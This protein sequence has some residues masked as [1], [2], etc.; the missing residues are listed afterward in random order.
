MKT[1]GLGSKGGK[2]APFESVTAPLGSLNF[3]PFAF[4]VALSST[5]FLL[6]AADPDLSRLP[7]PATV[8][9][10]FERDIRPIF[11]GHCYK[12][13]GPERPKG[14]FQLTSRESALKGGA[15]N[16]DDIIP[17]D[18][19]H[20]K[21]IWYVAALVEDMEMPPSGKGEPLTPT[22]IGLLRAWIDQGAP[23]TPADTAAER[24]PKFTITPA[25]RWFSVEGN[26]NKFR[27]HTWLREGFSGG[28]QDLSIQQ[29]VDDHTTATLDAR[30]LGGQGDYRVSLGLENPEL[31]FARFGVEQYRKYFDDTGGYYPPFS[32]PALQ[33]DRDLFL[34]IGRAWAEVG[35]SVP[36]WPRMTL[37]Y[38][39]A[40]KDGDKS[41]LQW[42]DVGP[43]GAE[44]RKIYP[45]FKNVD[46]QVHIIKF[47]IAHEIRGV[48]IEDN[49]RAEFYDL[50][51]QRQNSTF[52]LTTANVDKRIFVNEGHDHTQIANAFRL[53]KKVLDWVFLSGG[54]LYSHLDGD[55]AFNMNTLVSPAPFADPARVVGFFPGGQD[56]F[57]SSQQIL[58]EQH[59]HVFNANALLGPWQALTLSAGVQ[60][61]WMRQRG[62]G[63]IQLDQGGTFGDPA[64][65]ASL[66]SDIDTRR[67]TESVGLRFTKIPFTVLFA[68]ARLQQ[69]S[70]G[71]FEQQLGGSG[72]F[73]RDTDATA[74]LEEFK[75]GF[76]VS[77]W[78]Q[79]SFQ[80][81]YKRRDSHTDYDHTRDFLGFDP[82]TGAPF[83]GFGYPAFIRSRDIETDEAEAKLILRPASWIKTTLAY[84]IQARDYRAVTD[85]YIIPGDQFFPALVFSPG[86]GVAAGNYDAHIY[87]F[88]ATI[89]PLRRLYLSATFSYYDSRMGTA[90][91]NAPAVVDYEG[92]VY[93]LLSSAT[94][95]LDQKT[96]FFARYNFSKADYAQDNVRT[97]LPLGISYDLHGMEVGFSRKFRD[98]FTT[99]LGYAFYHYNEPSSGE[100][101]NY[102]AHGVFASLTMLWP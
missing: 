81:H 21:L 96:D 15:E 46:E 61:E 53:E 39:Y 102:T 33:L 94:Y 52:N 65:A 89:T 44:T 80:A 69:E 63:A 95:V 72:D 12:C 90:A 22:Q 23:W 43:Q 45:A 54:Y 13:H 24:Q 91:N 17:G 88:N 68:D 30:I 92:N 26:E 31:G 60:A 7:P 29:K 101:N 50:A 34:N 85:P 36:N 99:N 5:S 66:D 57:W 1:P 49:V 11:E 20:S 8:K 97:S 25:I 79:V 83:E 35:L 77:P 47:D 55:A 75:T 64:A 58:L 42:G 82:G 100:V 78:Q 67:I 76:A 74:H 40:Y 51:T 2:E 32:P 41:T 73:L 62:L 3:R 14:K 93:S 70:V 16:K 9:V 4:V 19:A 37:G 56:R 18:S 38:E 10:E 6:N 87:S 98:K 59:S 27:E 71:Q 86:G 84:R 48:T 28:L